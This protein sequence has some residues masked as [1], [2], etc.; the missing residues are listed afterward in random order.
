MSDLTQAVTV[1]WQQSGVTVVDGSGVTTSSGALSGS[2]QTATLAMTSPSQ[3][4][5]YTCKVKSAAFS[6]SEA[7]EK[8]VRLRVYREYCCS[9]S[10]L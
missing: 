8:T 5:E 4:E 9:F 2:S 3:D 7:S 1:T 10:G 6:D